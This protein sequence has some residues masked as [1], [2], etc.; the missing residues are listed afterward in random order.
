ME[1]ITFK[2]A[3]YTSAAGKYDELAPNKGN[4]DNFFVKD[5]L[6][7]DDSQGFHTDE[8]KKLSDCGLLMVVT[9]G[10][11]GM[12]AGEV[13]SEIAIN[14]VKEYFASE[15]ITSQLAS[16]HESRKR[17]MEQVIIESDARIKKDAQ[18]STEHEGMGSTIILA[19][20]VGNELSISW[21]GD[22][23]A[24]RF[25]PENGL[26]QLSKD[27]SYVQELVDKGIISEESAFD[28]PQGNIITRSLG[29]P[30]KKAK[31]DTALFHIS[32]SDIIMLCSDG[33]S[34]VLRDKQIEEIISQHTSSMQ[35]CREILFDEAEKAD[36]YDNV[37]VVLCGIVDAPIIEVTDKSKRKK[38][39]SK[40]KKLIPLLI[41]LILS[42]LVFIGLKFWPSKVDTNSV[43][44]CD[45]AFG[46]VC[47]ETIVVADTPEANQKSEESVVVA[48]QKTKEASASGNEQ[49]NEHSNTPVLTKITDAGAWKEAKRL[50]TRESYEQYISLFPEGDSILPAKNILEEMII[51]NME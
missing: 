9:D 43:D 19:W 26:E 20:I 6:I 28:H 23:R 8:K 29:D 30:D 4:E 25:N 22:S 21:C 44:E 51:N 32:Q 38:V 10:M 24:Y 15:K 2:I 34:G 40:L 42:C 47:N 49:D 18:Q 16:T 36:W 41:I 27:H 50:N 11:G 39:S 3:A 45:S 31:P 1:K 46:D 48:P 7:D 33:L 37:T 17:Y 14:T 5:N 12:N 13:A 35:D